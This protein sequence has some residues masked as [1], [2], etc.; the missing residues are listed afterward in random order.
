MK[1]ITIQCGAGGRRALTRLH[2]LLA[3]SDATPVEVD[4][5]D[6]VHEGIG[7]LAESLAFDATQGVLPGG[8]DY[9]DVVRKVRGNRTW[10]EA[11]ASRL[12]DE[13]EVYEQPVRL[14]FA[15]PRCKTKVL[16]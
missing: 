13:D 4:L 1:R 6:T 5:P 16:P 7:E 12:A 2:A 14:V 9:Y 8:E 11:T 10:I 15:P 3:W